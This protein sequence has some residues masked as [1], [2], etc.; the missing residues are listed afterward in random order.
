VE[1][2]EQEK[3]ITCVL[4]A[5]PLKWRRERGENNQ[6]PDPKNL[7]TGPTEEDGG[8]PVQSPSRRGRG[9]V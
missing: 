8:E 6:E 5:K 1:K 3:D 2:K 9:N 4:E 7:K